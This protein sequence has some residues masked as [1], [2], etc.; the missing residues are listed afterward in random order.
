MNFRIS[1]CLQ[2]TGTTTHSIMSD[3]SH[4]KCHLRWFAR[5]SLLSF[6]P[7]CWNYAECCCTPHKT[8][9]LRVSKCLHGTGTTTHSLM[10][11]CSH[12]K[13]HLC[14]VAQISLLCFVP[15]CWNYA[16]Y[17]FSPHKTIKLRISKCLQGTSTPTYFLVKTPDKWKKILCF[18]EVK[19]W[20]FNFWG[21][22]R[23][24]G[25]CFFYL[26]SLTLQSS[27]LECFWNTL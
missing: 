24:P 21:L 4:A 15:Y 19:K 6:V 16:E 5:M 26:G 23:N 17:C 18:F 22:G 7:Y 9:K 12:A 11:H 1:K 8:M 10:S 3:C 27:K 14:W 13:C 20:F 25:M 2:G